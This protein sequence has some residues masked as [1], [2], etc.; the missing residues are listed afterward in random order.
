MREDEM[1]KFKTH[2]FQK[3]AMRF[4]EIGIFNPLNL[5]LVPVGLFVMGLATGFITFVQSG[6]SVPSSSETIYLSASVIAVLAFIRLVAS[7]QNFKEKLINRVFLK[8]LKECDC[9]RTVDGYLVRLHGESIF[10]VSK[11][12]HV[13]RLKRNQAFPTSCTGARAFLQDVRAEVYEAVENGR[14]VKVGEEVTDSKMLREVAQI[15]GKLELGLVIVITPSPI[16]I[17]S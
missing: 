14:P 16:E 4:V 9:I 3:L 8:K 12:G 2:N 7:A 5:V 6:H 11:T 10:V 1:T 17:L 13:H 15:V